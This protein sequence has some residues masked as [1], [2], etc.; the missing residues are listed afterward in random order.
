ME[1]YCDPYHSEVCYVV[2]VYYVCFHTPIGVLQDLHDHL[3][4]GAEEDLE[5]AELKMRLPG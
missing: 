3:K 2:C 1:S 5:L 4:Q